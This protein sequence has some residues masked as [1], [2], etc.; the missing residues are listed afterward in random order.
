MAARRLEVVAGVVPHATGDGRVLLTQRPLHKVRGGLWEFPGGKLEPGESPEQ[1]LRRELRE[2]LDIE[3]GPTRRVFGVSHAYPDLEIRLHVCRVDQWRGEPRLL[4]A[5]QLT[6]RRTTEQDSAWPP[7]SQADQRVRRWLR[8]PTTLVVSADCPPGNEARWLAA[9]QQVPLETLLLVRTPALGQQDTRRL[10]DHLLAR[11]PARRPH[12]LL[13]GDPV[14][15]VDMG[16]GVQLKAAQLGHS[17]HPRTPLHL[18]G[19]SCHNALELEQ[20]AMLGCDYAALGPV[21]PTPTHP[22]APHLGWPRFSQLAQR[23]WLP[24]FALGGMTAA[25]HAQALGC[26]GHGVAGIRGVWPTMPAA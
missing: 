25:D 21:L 2:E 19:A 7:L 22:G 18:L 5:Q 11:Q 9:A 20:A 14:G 24:V 17:P 13:S 1:A 4:D 8:I 15:A 23:A 16:I 10:C 3:I 6:W 12:L 26:G